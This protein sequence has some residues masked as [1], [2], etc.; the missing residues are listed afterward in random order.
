[1]CVYCVYFVYIC[2]Y[3]P[4]DKMILGFAFHR[5]VAP[6]HLMCVRLENDLEMRFKQKNM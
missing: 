3:E 2:M 4:T 6:E 5:T 1:M